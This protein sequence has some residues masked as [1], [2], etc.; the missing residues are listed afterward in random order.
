MHAVRDTLAEIARR[1]DLGAQLW[2][3]AQQLYPI[4]RSITGDGL[5]QT[6]AAVGEH[7]D[8][9]IVETP[10]G[11]A[12]FDWTVPPEWRIREAWIKDASGVKVV[13][14]ANN[15]LHVLNYS[16]PVRR[17]L[18]L[19]ELKQHVFTMPD[20]PTLI[21]YRTSYYARKWGFCMSHAQL[22]SLPDG[23]YEVFID[24]EHDDAGS[25][26]YGECFLQGESDEIFLFS[27]HCCHPSLANDNCSGISVAAHL[28]EAIATL[29]GKTRYSYLFLFVPGTI[30]A[31]TW[32]ARNQERA[33][34]VKHGLVLAGLG[35][36]GGPMYKRSRRGDALIDRAAAHVLLQAETDAQ[37]RDFWPYGY[38]ERQY[39]SPAFN[40]PVGLM[41]RSQFATFPE[42]HTSADNM[43]FIKPEILERSFDRVL[44]IVDI[45]ENEGRPVNLAPH[46]EPNL[47]KRGL[48]AAVGGNAK[49]Y[50]AMLPILWVLNQADGDHS[51]LDIAARADLP[52]ERIRAA[53]KALADNGLLALET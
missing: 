53:A 14:F 26:T 29:K 21:P 33:L 4:C 17:K 7:V 23:E 36:L 41:Q 38:D 16:A 47:G 50:D 22:E 28:A 10:S 34:R 31:I 25:L 11:Q 32:L 48:Y 12:V 51:L 43:D 44:E 1:A 49:D 15:N 27:A 6:L 37:I 52:F 45:I 5:R 42:Y 9:K 20:R 40:L 35:D 39:C 30:G 18:P 24:S 13:D 46:C 8:L 2:R 3:F 19:V